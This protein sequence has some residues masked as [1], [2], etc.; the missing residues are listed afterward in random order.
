LWVRMERGEAHFNTIT[1][2]FTDQNII[3]MSI[4]KL[5]LM[6]IEC[7]NVTATYRPGDD[8]ARQEAIVRMI[9]KAK[10]LKL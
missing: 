7:E 4:I 2:T 3:G 6:R 10:I 9:S 8:R 5:Q 1:I